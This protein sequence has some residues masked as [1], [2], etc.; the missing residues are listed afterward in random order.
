MF[1][2]I[3]SAPY[4]LTGP[5][6]VAAF[7]LFSALGVFLFRPLGAR[8]LGQESTWREMVT[9]ALQICV[10]FFALLLAL[11]AITTV[12]N[13]ADARNKVSAEASAIAVLYRGV[14]EFPQPT[15]GELQKEIASYTRYVVYTSWPEQRR[16]KTP[17]GAI[18]IVSSMQQT[19][20]SFR[21]GTAAEGILLS[22]TVS[23]FQVFI[24]ARRERISATGESIPGLLSA[25]LTIG[26]L[27]TIALTWFLPVR[28]RA[29][30]WL[31][32]GVVAV[33]ASLILFTIAALSHPFRGSAGISPSPYLVL[34]QTRLPH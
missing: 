33:P 9:L 19:L 14:S 7:V 2:L 25:V 24:D 15:R 21:P 16:G 17:T 29:A 11:A 30:H 23:A 8:M 12:G 13:Y 1:E 27:I 4:P 22:S 20:F 3:Y 34:L 28:T 26:V 32:A 6:F 5:V 18:K 10:T 31:I